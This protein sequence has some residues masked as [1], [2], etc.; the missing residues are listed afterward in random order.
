M[1]IEKAT[2]TMVI[3]AN[4]LEI[5]IARL[6]DKIMRKDETIK[7]LKVTLSELVNRDKN[8]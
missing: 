4:T 5:Q 2:E 8:D 7:K 1:G 6:N 3:Y